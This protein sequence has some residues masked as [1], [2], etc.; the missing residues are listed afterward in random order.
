M[1]S[2]SNTLTSPGD[3]SLDIPGAAVGFFVQA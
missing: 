1:S 3:G 2:G